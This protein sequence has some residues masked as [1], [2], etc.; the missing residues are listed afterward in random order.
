MSGD[1]S[2]VDLFLF[3]SSYRDGMRV[4]ESEGSVQPS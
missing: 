4:V 2:F 1:Y 3:K